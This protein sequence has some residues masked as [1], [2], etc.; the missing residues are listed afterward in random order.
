MKREELE[1]LISAYVDD[2][3]SPEKKA[4]VEALVRSD[5]LAREIR[6]EYMNVRNVF[7]SCAK[8]MRQSVPA[9]FS[10]QVLQVIDRSAD[11]RPTVRSGEPY[12]A[13][14]AN[15]WR[16]RIRDNPRILA[17]P[18]L[19]LCI[20][21]LLTVSNRNSEEKIA[22][23][24]PGQTV[25]SGGTLEPIPGESDEN[26]PAFIPKT[27]LG[28]IEKT[29]LGTNPNVLPKS[30]NLVIICKIAKDKQNPTFFPNLFA[31]HG[32]EGWTQ[33]TGGIATGANSVYEAKIVRD[34]LQSIINELKENNVSVQIQI[35]EKTVDELPETGEPIKTRFQIE[36]L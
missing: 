28:D 4:D 25:P 8:A 21:L 1:I 20:A 34:T 30:K 13:S 35:V 24:D 19:V 27:P 10:K 3:L 9:D 14:A 16:E 17:Y 11:T 36:V 6:D 22:V 5:S 32:V 26:L 2:E 29:T 18:V 7:Q 12:S 31:Q 33:R 15:S 23:N